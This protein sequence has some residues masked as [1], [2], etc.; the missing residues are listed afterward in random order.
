MTNTAAENPT[1][2]RR[3]V[4]QVS[5]VLA[6]LAALCTIFASIATIA[7]SWQ[8]H[9]EA[10]WPQVAASV[11]NCEIAQTSSRSRRYNIRC[12]LKF[13]ANSQQVRANVYSIDVPPADALQYPPNQI[14][15][16]IDWVNAHPSGTPLAVR[17]NPVQPSKIVLAGDYMPMGELQTANDIKLTAACAVSF[18]VLFLIARITRPRPLKT[19]DYS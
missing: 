15:P 11:I 18:L 19:E 1:T 12:R 10:A 14:A 16:F 4:F 9:E 5:A 2:W 17:Y 8:E 3:F 6:A 7:N 13:T